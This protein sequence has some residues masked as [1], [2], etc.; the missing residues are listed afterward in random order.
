MAGA[1]YLPLST[2]GEDHVLWLRREQVQQVKWGHHPG[3]SPLSATAEKPLR[4][5]PRGSFETWVEEVRGRC[6]SWTRAQTQAALYL[7]QV[8]RNHL[9]SELKLRDCEKIPVGRVS[10]A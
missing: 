3:K 8:I 4:L 9:A 2:T 6:L 5:S 1:L 7:A 10:A